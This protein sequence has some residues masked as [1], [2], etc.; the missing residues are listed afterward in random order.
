MYTLRVWLSIGV[1]AVGVAGRSSLAG[2]PKPAFDD[3][4]ILAR[5]AQ[6]AKT[7]AEWAGPRRGVTRAEPENPRPAPFVINPSASPG[8]RAVINP[9]QL[10]ASLAPKHREAVT[11]LWRNGHL[12]AGELLELQIIDSVGFPLENKLSEYQNRAAG[13]EIVPGGTVSTITAEVREKMLRAERKPTSSREVRGAHHAGILKDPDYQIVEQ[14]L[15]PNGTISVRFKKWL[16][17]PEKPDGEWS[18]N[19]KSTLAP[20]NWSEE[21]IDVAT[22]I[23]Y[24]SGQVVKTEER[25]NEIVYYLRETL[26]FI[27]DAGVQSKPVEWEILVT[28]KDEVISSYPT[29]S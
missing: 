5:C 10:L 28:D 11:R 29:G 8:I 21:D 22:S 16:V 4:V 7:L 18:K 24:G 14:K 27:D 2:P 15:N 9:E 25:E 20:E 26:I 1:L 23:T 12:S 17:T 6:A 19:K 3:P 13:G